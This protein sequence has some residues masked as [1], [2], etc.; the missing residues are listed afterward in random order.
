MRQKHMHPCKQPVGFHTKVKNNDIK[1]QMHNIGNQYLHTHPHKH[2]HTHT[3]IHSCFPHLR[4]DDRVLLVEATQSCR[5][6][7]EVASLR[8]SRQLL[9]D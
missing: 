3:H 9:R 6:G 7:S 2:T 4:C 8:H 1:S 5:Q